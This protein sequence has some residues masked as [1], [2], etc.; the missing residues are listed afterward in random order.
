MCGGELVCTP[1]S[2][3]GHIFRGIIPYS[4]ESSG[5]DIVKKNS[6]RVAEVWMDEYK[7]Y[8]YERF[9]YRLG[10]YG[11]LSSR[12]AL[13]ERLKCNSFDWYVKNVYPELFVPSDNICSGEVCFFYG[14]FRIKYLII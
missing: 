12:K 1:C 6:I 14:A 3:V 4:F 2:H 13:R 5:H 8:Y 7:S 9:N 11:D 10:D